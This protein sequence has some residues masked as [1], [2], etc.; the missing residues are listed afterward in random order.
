MLA[1]LPA[2]LVVLD[3]CF[4]SAPVPVLTPRAVTVGPVALN[5]HWTALFSETAWI[6]T[7]LSWSKCSGQ[8]LQTEWSCC[9]RPVCPRSPVG[10]QKEICRW[11]F[12]SFLYIE[13][14]GPV[15]IHK[16]QKAPPNSYYH[17]LKMLFTVTQT[18][19]YHQ[20][21]FK[22]FLKSFREYCCSVRSPC[23]IFCPFSVV[24]QT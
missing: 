4:V 13:K 8:W 2:T 22:Y 3:S 20:H 19:F 24:L 11:M 18:T 5:T 17:I 14:I 12:C 21:V 23:H 6:Q 9:S 15:K 7:G 16:G 10:T 1:G